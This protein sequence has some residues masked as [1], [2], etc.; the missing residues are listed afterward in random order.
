[1]D[2]STLLPLKSKEI[3][4]N[5]EYTVVIQALVQRYMKHPPVDLKRVKQHASA[6]LTG[7]VP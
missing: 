4:E 5:K 6:V 2:P 1:M 3:F 7:E